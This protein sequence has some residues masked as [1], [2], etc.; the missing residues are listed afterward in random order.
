MVG[1]ALGLCAA[2]AVYFWVRGISAAEVA[3]ARARLDAA[4]QTQQSTAEA[5]R[6]K[7]NTLHVALAEVANV[8]AEHAATA[9]ALDAERRTMQ[10]KLATLDAAEDHLKNAFAA[11]SQEALKS[12]NESFLQ[13]A[14]STFEQ[15]QERAVGELQNREKAVSQLVLPLQQSLEVVGKNVAAIEKARID[16]Y[17]RI[18]EH[19]KSLASTQNALQ[20][21]TTHLVKA[22]RSPNVR[23]QWGEMQL[24]RVVEA[25]GMVEHCDFDFKESA[26]TDEGKLIPDLLVRLPG[27]KNVVVDSKVPASAFLEAI[28]ETDEDR[29]ELKFREHAR[30]LREHVNKLA[31]KSYWAHFQPTPDIVVMFLPGEALLSTALLHDP[32]L[33]EYSVSKGVMLASPL[34]LIGLLRAVA[35]GW[36]QEALTKNAQEISALG[37]QLYDRIRVLA[38]HL[39]DLRDHLHGSVDAYHRVLASL[40]SR[41]LV[42]AKKLKEM[43]VA[44]TKELP[45]LQPVDVA[46]RPP[47]N[48]ELAA[49]LGDTVVD[50]EIVTQGL[51]E[52][53]EV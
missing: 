29:R 15:F 2:L 4:L 13:L 37:Q 24:R 16:A 51:N 14:K 26:G 3:D 50:A 25:A 45:E 31:A 8:R 33:L 9:A 30:Q 39:E 32:T 11:L 36:Q 20:T 41:V 18:D 43:G 1:L 38:E 52:T 48:S 40:G 21:E 7:D 19:L 17:S 34:S 23:G 53:E 35:F 46:P 22:L 28:G 5:L 6:A 49:L 27:D 10:E 44:T 42:T 47:R 12:S